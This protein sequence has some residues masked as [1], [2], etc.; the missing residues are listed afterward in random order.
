MLRK[1]YN[2]IIKM[3]EF[4]LQIYKVNVNKYNGK[5]NEIKG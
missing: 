5:R 1:T 2:V 3:C 4:D